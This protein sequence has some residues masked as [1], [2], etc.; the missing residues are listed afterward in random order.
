MRSEELHAAQGAVARAAD[1]DVVVKRDTQGLGDIGDLP[2]HLD[3]GRGWG[4]IAR[5][6]IVELS[7]YLFIQLNNKVIL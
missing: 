7:I 1:D 6:M 5:W 2:R 3:V 4:G